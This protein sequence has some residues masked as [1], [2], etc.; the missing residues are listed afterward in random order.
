MAR[1]DGVV[2]VVTGAGSG[3]GRA[4]A[5]LLAEEGATVACLDIHAR[6]AEATAVEIGDLGQKAA[7][8]ECDVS[9]PSAVRSTVDTIAGSHGRPSILCN[10]A[11]VQQ[12]GHTM[13]LAFAD[14]NRILSIN[15]TGTFLMCQATLPYLTDGGGAIVNVASTA[16]ISALPY[17]AAYCASKAGVMMLTRSLAIEFSGSKVRINAVAPGGMNTPMLHLQPPEGASPHLLDRIPGSLFG[18]G[19]PEQV[20]RV[21]AFLASNEADYMS[22]SIVAVDGAAMA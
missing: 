13:D 22:G 1:F 4:T 21:I 16:G 14:W 20:A 7:S 9:D 10:I 18:V 2:A 11:A 5:T 19:Q 8:Y 6:A 3:L 17:D 15:L 12:W